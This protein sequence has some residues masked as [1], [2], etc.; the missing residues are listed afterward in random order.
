MAVEGSAAELPRSPLAIRG[1]QLAG[2]GVGA[3]QVKAQP[4]VRHGRLIMPVSAAAA[5]ARR[6]APRPGR[7]SARSHMARDQQVVGAVPVGRDQRVNR[8]SVQ[9][10]STSS[11]REV[12]TVRSC[13]YLANKPGAVRMVHYRRGPPAERGATGLWLGPDLQNASLCG[14]PQ[15]AAPACAG[16]MSAAA[17]A[18][19]APFRRAWPS[20][21]AMAMNRPAP[22]ER[23]PRVPKRS[24]I[25]AS[26]PRPRARRRAVLPPR[27]PLPLPRARRARS[28][29]GS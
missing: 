22:P 8:P 6:P 7:G 18:G 17:A 4:L 24:R 27:A 16:R 12:S 19:R 15:Q 21:V 3:E 25:R 1:Q 29:A 23:P 13:A 20:G 28:R 14:S 11:M 26:P 5:S 2:H 9:T 10:K